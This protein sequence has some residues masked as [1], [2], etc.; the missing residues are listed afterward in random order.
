MKDNSS[1]AC[2]YRDIDI[3]LLV[4]DALDEV[5]SDIDFDTYDERQYIPL[6]YTIMNESMNQS[7][8]VGSIDLFGVYPELF[9][10][11]GGPRGMHVLHI[12]CGNGYLEWLKSVF[13]IGI[14]KTTIDFNVKDQGG[15]A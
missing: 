12:A 14:V 5:N 15:M 8:S 2:R 1:L 3:V 13:M 4:Q 10:V 9:N 6:H 7:G 11:L